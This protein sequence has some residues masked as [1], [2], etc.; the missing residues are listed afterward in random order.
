MGD[1]EPN[2][3]AEASE[4]MGSVEVVSQQ[5]AINL[6]WSVGGAVRIVQRDEWASEPSVVFIRPEQV[7]Q[8]VEA[9]QDF[10]A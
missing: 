3:Q 7:A 2:Q 10:I 9:L 8:F 4:E 1:S 6:E 5:D